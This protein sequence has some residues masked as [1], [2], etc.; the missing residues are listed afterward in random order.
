MTSF[1]TKIQSNNVLHFSPY[2]ILKKQYYY[3]RSFQHCFISK[4]TDNRLKTKLA[5]VKGV[6]RSFFLLINRNVPMVKHDNINK[7]YCGTKIIIINN[8]AKELINIKRKRY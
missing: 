4:M 3:Q 6:C 5:K 7:T 2:E 8:I 1:K